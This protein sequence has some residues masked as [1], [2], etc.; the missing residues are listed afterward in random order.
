MVNIKDQRNTQMGERPAQKLNLQSVIR[1]WSI[2]LAVVCT[3]HT[4]GWDPRCH[5]QRDAAFWDGVIDD[6]G[7]RIGIDDGEMT[8]HWAR[9]VHEGQ[10]VMN[11]TLVN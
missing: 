1:Q 6:Y 3:A 7:L 2:G 9:K 8:H 5:V 10:S 11:V 4:T